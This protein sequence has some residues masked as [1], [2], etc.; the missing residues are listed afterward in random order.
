MNR[1]RTG[2]FGGTFDPVHVGHL[3]IAEAV[4]AHAALDR[5]LWLPVGEPAHRETHA[6]AADRHAMLELAIE[7]NPH[8]V[9]DDTALD[10]P[11]PAY[12]A[13]TLKLLQAKY[14]DDEFHFIAG[15]DSLVRSHWRRLD[16][17][18]A[19]LKTFWVV[20]REGH[21]NDDLRSALSEVPAPLRSRFVNVGLP[22]VDVS[23]TT[24]RARVAAHEPITYLV[25][26]AV[27]TY[28]MVHGLYTG[29]DSR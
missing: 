26:K 11:G 12:T 19:A 4:L 6:P 21:G 22:L 5:V 18:A 9:L 10:Q 17:V 27:E 28:I 23:A 1:R 7:A 8:F 15:V 2:L 3:F 13:D 25:P 14:P 20:R 29:P 16:E 24:I